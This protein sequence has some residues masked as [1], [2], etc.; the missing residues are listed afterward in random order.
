M[1]TKIQLEAQSI[2]TDVLL[3]KYAKGNETNA[4]DIQRRVSHYVASVESTLDKQVEWEEKF[5]QNMENGAM[6]AGRIMSAAGAGIKATLINCFVQPVGDC[7]QGKDDEGFAGIY[8]A[9]REAAETMRRGGGVGYDF[10]R[11]RPRNAFVKG[12][13][14][15]A[16]GPCSYMDVFDASCKTVES[17]GCFAG[18]TLIQTTDGLVTIKEIVES[19]KQFY[20]MTH[21]GPKA[22]TAKFKNGIKPIWNVTTEYGY[23]VRVTPEHKFAQFEDGKIVT[24]ELKDIYFSNN[25]S[26]LVLIPNGQEVKPV[27]SNDEMTAYL[28]G[29]F[30][31]NGCWSFCATT[32]ETS[33]YPKG[34]CI[35]NNTTKENIVDKIVGFAKQLGLNPSKS[36]HPNENTLEVRIYDTKYFQNWDSLG[37]NKGM[38]MRVPEFI[39]KGTDGVRAAYVAGMM[40][41]DGTISETKSNLRLRLITKK[42]LKDIQVILAGFGVPATLKLERMGI[43]GWKDIF[44]LGIYGPVAQTRFNATV[45]NF[46]DNTLVSISS[47]D[48]V[49]FSHSWANVSKFGVRS[50]DV[51]EFWCG[52]ERTHPNISLNALVSKTQVPELIN[53]V[54]DRIKFVTVEDSEEVFDVEV[55]DVHLLSGDGIYTS[56]SRRG[57]QMGVLKISHPDIMEFVTA[58]RTPGRWNNFNVSVFVTDA[59]MKAKNE[60]TAWQ[61]VHKAE[62]AQALKDK[63]AFKRED[64]LWVYSEI[65][66]AELWNNIMKSNYDFAEPGILFEDNINN[67]NNLRYVERLEATNPCVTGDT[68]ILTSGGYVR[69]DSVVDQ[70]VQVWNGFEYS[71]VTPRVTGENQEIFDLEF[72]DG[73]KLA[74]TPYH[75]FILADGTRVE[76]KD[77]QLNSKLAKFDYPVI[78][79]GSVFNLVLDKDTIINDSFKSKVEW[80]NSFLDNHKEINGDFNSVTLSDE[81]YTNFKNL[82]RFLN[83]LGTTAKLSKKGNNWDLV[84]SKPSIDRLRML[85]DDNNVFTTQ[86]F[87]DIDI[88]EDNIELISKQKRNTL[89]PKVYCFTEDKNH[90]G[91]FN[92]LMTANCGEQPLPNYGCC[93]LGPINLTKFVIEPF[94][95]NCGFN[96]GAFREAVTIQV[97]FLDNVLDATLWPL[98]QQLEESSKKRRVGVGFTGLGNTLAMLGLVYGSQEALDFCEDIARTM[99]D[100]AYA[101]S[102]DLA[103]EKGAFPLF[104]ADKYL[105]EGTF[106]S[107]LPKMIKDDIRKYGIRNSHLLSI[108]PTGTVSLAFCDNASNGIEPPFSLAYLRKKRNSDNTTTQYP[109]VDHGLRVFL[110]TIEVS[111]A[112]KILDTV[113]A[114]KTEFEYEGQVYSLKDVLPKSLITAMELTANEHLSALT[115]IQ[116]YIDSAISKTVNVPADYPFEDFKKIYDNAHT[117][118]L[119][120]VSTYRPNNIIGSVLSLGTEEKKP[121]EKAKP[122]EKETPQNVDPLNVVIQRRSDNDLEA[123][124]KKVKYMTSLGDNTFYVSVSF[125]NVKGMLDG[126][127][128]TVP[129]PVE[130]FITA[131]PDGVPGEWVAAYARA[132]S[133]LARSG[134]HMFCRT[135]VDSRA[136]KSDKGSIRYGT[137]VKHDGTKVPRWHDSDVGCIAY[138]VQEILQKKGIIDKM[139]TPYSF[140]DIATNVVQVHEEV[141]LEAPIS[142]ETVMPGKRC[143]ECGAHAVIKKDGCSYCTSCGYLGSCG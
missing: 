111:F 120:G 127:P 102:V 28:V 96:K 15:F 61:L 140:K 69:I 114:Y 88:F 122:V 90:S 106:A 2:S 54:S 20:A 1:T 5:F 99:R 68:V 136:I 27:W 25:H 139:G 73:T 22:I 9:I 14:S 67:D 86:A 119:K 70:E 137:Y 84:I 56:N 113:C 48:R 125:E 131:Y 112:E 134:L 62:P 94:S 132:L 126:A 142:Q 8:E 21:V 58:K 32:D 95:V 93:D 35:T 4:V 107:R 85:K 63:G 66:A 42:L 143:T 81:K 55:E 24:K 65:N 109:V 33:T 116:P 51:N 37:I 45:G 36:K 12:T 83:T 29:A 57:A 49:G 23:N 17:A 44:C 97:R 80:I 92:G 60:N 89:E 74:C 123:I 53:T 128:V 115:V 50:S 98:P 34:I 101:A 40:E 110:G 76:A 108:A 71:Y 133:L 118:R 41:A 3:E 72:S 82:I 64:G 26:V 124:T 19:D 130:V 129:R 141:T 121:E 59:F 75:K 117:Y 11:I 31:G 10:S 135:L 79:G 91:I 87:K 105:E 13:H 43:D 18:N 6:G 30:Q 16:S 100:N 52:V 7:I 103:R 104:D 39:L 38:E 77:L 46:M 138:A 47:R 78:T